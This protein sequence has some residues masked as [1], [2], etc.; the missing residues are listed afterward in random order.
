MCLA[1]FDR[2]Q[3]QPQACAF[4]TPQGIARLVVHADDSVGVHN[5][6]SGGKCWNVLKLGANVGLVTEEYEA[7]FW[8]TLKR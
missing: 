4:A 2:L 7:Q 3:C 1:G 6:R 5:A 8:L